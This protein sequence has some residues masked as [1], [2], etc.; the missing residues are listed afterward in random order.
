M[1]CHHQYAHA[2]NSP[3]Y[4]VGRVMKGADAAMEAAALRFGLNVTIRPV[5]LV[6]SY[7]YEDYEDDAK[8]ERKEDA[9]LLFDIKSTSDRHLAEGWWKWIGDGFKEM[10]L[11]ENDYEEDLIDNL[12]DEDWVTPYSGIHWLNEALFEEANVAYTRVLAPF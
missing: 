3:E 2:A 9:A 8:A 7:Q 10:E 1:Y 6:D 11:W 12:A 4:R 5:Y